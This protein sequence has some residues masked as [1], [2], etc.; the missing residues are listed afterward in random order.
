MAFHALVG[1]LLCIKRFRK[2]VDD[3]DTTIPS[4]SMQLGVDMFLFG[5]ARLLLLIGV[6]GVFLFLP[7]FLPPPHRVLCLLYTISLVLVHAIPVGCVFRWA[8]SYNMI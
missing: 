1:P 4:G 6:N 2:I 5:V 7:P 3:V 8:V